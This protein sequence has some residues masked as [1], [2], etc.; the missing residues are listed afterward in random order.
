MTKW[1]QLADGQTI[2]KTVKALEQNGIETVIVKTGQEAKKKVLAIIPRGSEVMTM[3]SVTLDTI[4]ISEEINKPDSKFKPIRDKLYRLDRKTQAQEM[5]HL[6][7]APQFVVGSVQAI[8]EDGQLFNGFQH[9]QPATGLS[10]LYEYCL[11]LES[12]RA[13][14][15]YGVPGSAINKILII[16]KEVQ[17]KRATLILVKEKLGF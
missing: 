3:S 5:N 12:E 4:G 17:P 9:R 11:L 10:R 16:N 13:K 15:V 2:R 6:G 7:A 8:T 14:K 1:D